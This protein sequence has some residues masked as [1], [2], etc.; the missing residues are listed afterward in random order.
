MPTERAP[1]E[2]FIGVY[3]AEGTLRGELAY[4]FGS[5]LGRAHCALCDITHG[6]FRERSDWKRCCASLPVPFI[7]YHLN[8][9]PAGVRP[10]TAGRTPA[11]LADTT[12]GPVLLLDASGLADV[13]GDPEALID[14]LRRAV[15][16]AGLT[17]PD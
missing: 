2:R 11:V 3:H 8:D 5:R 13:R 10:L 15:S 17:W 4:W 9:Q 12:D 7:T 14:L 6:S 16:T 1:I